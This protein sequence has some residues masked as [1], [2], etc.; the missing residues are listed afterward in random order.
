[1][2]KPL[3]KSMSSTYTYDCNG[4]TKTLKD[5]QDTI[6]EH[7]KYFCVIC[8]DCSNVPVLHLLNRGGKNEA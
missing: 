6:V 3:Y 4:D 7:D 8:T 2:P 5:D 1:M